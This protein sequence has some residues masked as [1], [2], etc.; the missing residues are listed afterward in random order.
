MSDTTQ[1]PAARGDR[2]GVRW[3]L[4]G[5]VALRSVAEVREQARWASEVGF[6][7]FWVSQGPAVD[8]VEIGRAHV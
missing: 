8:P 5:G 2:F 3:G 4:A 7:S 1:G 6:D